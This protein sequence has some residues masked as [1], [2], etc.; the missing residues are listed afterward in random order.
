MAVR[1]RGCRL[2]TVFR[3]LCGLGQRAVD[4]EVSAGNA[5]RHRARQEHGAG[6]LVRESSKMTDIV[7]SSLDA[8]RRIDAMDRKILRVLLE[9]ASLSVAEIGERVGLSSTPCWKRIQR[10]EGGGIITG[11][12]ALVDQNKID[13]GCP[14]SYPF[15]AATI[16]AH[17]CGSLGRRSAPC[18]KG[19]S[20]IA[21]PAMSIRCC[22][23]SSRTCTAMIFSTRSSSARWR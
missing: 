10:M 9:Y 23:S 6:I 19:W 18:R 13:L 21:W 8:R 20:S 15:K 2:S 4:D 12:V 7:A 22:A 16:P 14:Y 1:D 17:G 5:P 3:S 11:K